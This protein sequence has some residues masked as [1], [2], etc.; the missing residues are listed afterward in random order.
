MALRVMVFILREFK[1]FITIDFF[2]NSTSILV[3]FLVRAIVFTCDN[4]V[5]AFLI[6]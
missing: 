2:V 3:L 6:I 1:G 5:G 4:I